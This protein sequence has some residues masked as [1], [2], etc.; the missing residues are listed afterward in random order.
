MFF[1]VYRKGHFDGETLAELEIN[2]DRNRESKARF[3]GSTENNSLP[4][5][6]PPA[7]CRCLLQV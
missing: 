1:T 3:Q 2:K 6:T 7:P 5:C 4:A